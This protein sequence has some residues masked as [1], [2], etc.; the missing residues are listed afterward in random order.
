MSNENFMREAIRLSVDGVRSGCGGPFGCVVVRDGTT[1]IE[2]AETLDGLWR[3][4]AA[5]IDI[6]QQ[7]GYSVTSGALVKAVR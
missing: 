6:E 5:I 2:T 4:K 1:T 3:T 7:Y